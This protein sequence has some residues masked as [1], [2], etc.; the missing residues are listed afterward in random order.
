MSG[1]RFNYTFLR[2]VLEKDIL[3]RITASVY[4]QYG[5]ELMKHSTF[6]RRSLSIFGSETIAI[7]SSIRYLNPCNIRFPSQP[8]KPC[9][10]RR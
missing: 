4:G 6:N 10:S 7:F 5:R 2:L 9:C 3:R 1:L 8:F